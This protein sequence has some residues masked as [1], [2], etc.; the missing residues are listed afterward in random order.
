MFHFWLL[1]FPYFHFVGTVGYSLRVQIFFVGGIMAHLKNRNGVW[2]VQYKESGKWKR[3]S[4]KTKIKKIAQEYLKKFQRY[5]DKGQLGILTKKPV[6]LGEF[7]PRHLEHADRTNS[8]RWAHDKRWTFNRYLLPYFGE[9][10]PLK[11]ITIAKIEAYR[12]RRKR[13]QVSNRTVNLECTILMR[14]LRQAVEWGELDRQYLPI[15]K[16]LKQSVGRL[17][18]LSRE[19]IP[20]LREAAFDHSPGMAA[21]VMLMLHAGLRSGEALALRWVDV[22]LDQRV[23]HIAP[24]AD[25]KPKT[26]TAR[27][28]PLTSELADFLTVRR[29]EV[30]EDALLV[31]DDPDN[32]PYM[33]KRRLLGVIKAAGLPVT[34]ENRVT[35][36]TLRHTFA[37]HLVTSGVPLYTVGMLL[38][39]TNVSTTQIYAHLAP[40]HLAAAVKK[41]EY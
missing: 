8:P 34:G 27:T 18:F 29:A 40:D 10:T 33:L 32:T 17:R 19:E 41:I 20:L 14:C 30:R 4:C 36:H 26:S 16:R 12:S 11:E 31:V 24:R 5:E 22:D 23:L 21:Y 37:S 28:V 13:D 15:I 7:V 35:A 39:H 38:G 6:T 2:Y 25:W 9:D 3:V 1:I